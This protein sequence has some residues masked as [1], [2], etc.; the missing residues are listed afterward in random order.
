M[1]LG[2]FK[3]TTANYTDYNLVAI[4]THPIITHIPATCIA[5]VDIA[6]IIKTDSDS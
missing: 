6:V 5:I 1:S 4:D 2:N 3:Q